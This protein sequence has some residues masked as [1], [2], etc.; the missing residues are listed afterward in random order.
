MTIKEILARLANVKETASGWTACCPGHEDRQ[1]SLSVSDGGEGRVLLHC[2][3]G[4]ALETITSG[5]GITKADLFDKEAS[6]SRPAA[7]PKASTKKAAPA[8]DDETFATADAALKAYGRG[9]PT[10]VHKYLDEHGVHVSS[11]IRWSASS[12]TAGERITC[13]PHVRSST[14]WESW[15]PPAG[16][17]SSRGR[18]A[19]TP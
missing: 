6:T 5:L 15:R 9:R 19:S 2:H 11:V 4:C 13:Q 16:S 1:A 12:L 3:A 7:P 8:K 17:T 10:T 18:S 14:A